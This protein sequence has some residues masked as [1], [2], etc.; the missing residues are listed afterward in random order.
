MQNDEDSNKLSNEKNKLI[1]NLLQSRFSIITQKEKTINTQKEKKTKLK[2]SV[3]ITQ[4]IKNIKQ[5]LL[6]FMHIIKQLEVIEVMDFSFYEN[7]TL[8]ADRIFNLFFIFLNSFCA[9]C[10]ESCNIP[11]ESHSNN[12]CSYR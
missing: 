11:S 7:Q 2:C 6:S 1:P 3:H 12:W 8:T 10:K 4:F 9:Y 5:F